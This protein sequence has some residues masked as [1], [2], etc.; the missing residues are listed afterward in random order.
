LSV[1]TL[2]QWRYKK[3]GPS[4]LKFGAKVMYRSDKVEEWIESNSVST[5]PET[6]IEERYAV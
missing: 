4:F 3:C 5:N 6:C 1:S 2:K